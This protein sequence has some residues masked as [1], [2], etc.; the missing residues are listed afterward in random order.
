[1]K[2]ILRVDYSFQSSLQGGRLEA[3]GCVADFI[4]F[5]YTTKQ[6]VLNVQG[7]T[8]DDFLRS[9]KDR[10]QN[11]TLESMGFKVFEIDM[12]VVYD[13][14]LFEDFMRKLFGLAQGFSGGGGAFQATEWEK[15]VP[16]INDGQLDYIIHAIQ[17]INNQIEVA[18][19]GL[20]WHP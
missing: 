3:G 11:A 17:K 10:E 1:L 20:A 13:V 2:D 15:Y 12:D 7:E 8:H 4:I 5:P 14:Y 18:K 19:S 6:F 16:E 9:A